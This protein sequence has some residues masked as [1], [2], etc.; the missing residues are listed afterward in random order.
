[1]SASGS[2]TTGQDAP[3]SRDSFF[4]PA[5]W[6]MRV[7]VAVDPVNE[8]LLTR[9]SLTSASPSSPPGPVSTDSTPSGR[10]ASTKHAASAKRGQRGGA[11]RLEHDGVAGGQRRRELVQHQQ[12]R[13]VERRDGHHHADRLAD[14]ETDLVETRSGVRV[15]RQRITVELGSFERRQPDQLTGPGRLAAGLG[16]GLAGLGADRLRD[17]LGPLVGQAPPPATGSASADG[18]GCAARPW[19]PRSRRRAQR[20]HP[21]ETCQGDRPD[22]RPV[23]RRGHILLAARNGLGPLATDQ[24]LH[25]ELHPSTLKAD[26]WAI[27]SHNRRSSSISVTVPTVAGQA[28]RSIKNTSYRSASSPRVAYSETVPVTGRLAKPSPIHQ[29]FDGVPPLSDP[30]DRPPVRTERGDRRP[31]AEQA[32]RRAGQHRGE[33]RA[34]DHRSRPAAQPASAQRPHLHRRRRHADTRP[35]LRRRQVRPGTRTADAPAGSGE[36]EIRFPGEGATRRAGEDT[37]RHPPPRFHGRHPQGTRRAR[38]Q[39]TRSGGCTTPGFRSS[40]WSPTSP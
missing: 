13:V 21:S 3:S 24:Q 9:G 20:R 38:D 23:E 33:R 16:D 32:P 22:D 36:I 34:G 14:G 29:D 2:T 11:S 19:R 28:S 17:R 5:S 15:Q 8:I 6:V 30:R 35:V 4:T 25:A 10:P 37:R 26:R 7:P 31:R 27:H 12:G 39:S 40:P 18:P 1:M